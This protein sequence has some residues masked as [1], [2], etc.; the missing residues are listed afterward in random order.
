MKL[1][2]WQQDGVEAYGLIDGG[3]AH[4]VSNG[5]R[6]RFPDLHDVLAAAA[7]SDLRADA[8]AQPP[9]P[10]SGITW[11]LPIHPAARVICVGINYPKRYPLDQSVTRPENIILFAKLD[12]TLVPH[13]TPLEI[14]VGEAAESFDYEGEIGVVIGRAARHISP[15]QAHA[16]IAG[17]TVVNDGSVREWQ[18]HSVHAGKNFAASGGCGPWI[19][20]ADEIDVPEALKLTTRLN[21]Q[22]VQHA[23]ASEM[24]FS[25][26]QVIS[27][28]SHMIPLHPGDLIAMGS[29]DGT[30]GSRSP[31]RFLKRGDVLEIDVPGVG[32]LCNRV[33]TD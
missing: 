21:G 29:P 19:T 5:F 22:I 11:R 2:R 12:G 14:P 28:I 10:V 16:H 23:S 13:D 17:F 9:V 31:Q 3:N 4:P 20:T 27:Y 8:L 25:I 26:P 32:V 30:G 1:A 6:M 15:D 7:L 24:F 18:K 33:G